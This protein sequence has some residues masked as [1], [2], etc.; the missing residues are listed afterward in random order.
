MLDK[1]ARGTALMLL[2]VLACCMMPRTWLTEL[3]EVWTLDLRIRALHG[4]R[5]VAPNA[6]KEPT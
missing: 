5:F 1:G 6:P 2:T 4:A 3:V